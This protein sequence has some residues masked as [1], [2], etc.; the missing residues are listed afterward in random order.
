VSISKAFGGKRVEWPI[1]A[2]LLMVHG[3]LAVLSIR[4]K[5]MTFDE[6]LFTTAGYCH[7]TKNDYRLSPES[8]TLPHRWLALPLVLGD[9]R[10]PPTDQEAWRTSHV[11]RLGYEFHYRLG[12]DHAR[13]LFSARVMIVVLSLAL[14]L[15]VYLW[16]RRLFGPG[17]ARVCLLLYAFSP[18]V[19][20]HARLATSDLTAGLLLTAALAA[21][22]TVLHTA[23]PLTLLASCLAV[24]GAVLA[25]MSGILIL[26]MALAMI[27]IRLISAGPLELRFGKPRRLSRRPGRLL[28]MLA[29]L[30]LHAAFVAL[31]IWA[32]FGFRYSAFA[33]GDAAQAR[34]ARPWWNVLEEVG[35]AGPVVAAAREHRLLP[36]AYL[37]GLAFTLKTTQTRY[38][39]FNG[40]VSIHGWRSFFPYCLLVKTPLAVFAVLLLALGAAARRW[41]G[42]ARG[43]LSRLAGRV[44]RSLYRTA[45]LWVLLAVYWT[46][47]IASNLN[48]GHRHILPTYPA[49]FILCGAAAGW[50]KASPRVGR[51]AAA[52]LAALLLCSAVESLWI[53]PHYLAY[54]NSIAGG[55]DGGHKH[56]VDSSLDWGQD[57]PGLKRWLRRNGLSDAEDA[58]VYLSYFGSGNPRYHALPVRLLPCYFDWEPRRVQ[59]PLRGGTYCVSATMLQTPYLDYPG[60][61]ARAY[62]S[63]YQG[64]REALL[65]YRSLPAD[66]RKRLVE[67]RPARWRDTLRRFEQLQ[68]ARLFAFLR[69]RGFD[70]HVG[71]SILIYRLGDGEVRRALEEPPAE[72]VESVPEFV[73]EES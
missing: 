51:F 3:A 28:A 55:P 52:V 32:V 23:R 38:A 29:I 50:L 6:I 34:F 11:W 48:I 43:G 13:M 44:A 71:Y 14:G 47:A 62:E 45:P 7:W 69:W 72:L 27:V 58:P 2:V 4:R 16:S 33:G 37:Y 73:K 68:L 46:A 56:L 39:F 59:F 18:T 15:L 49:M 64:L 54:F 31:A 30:V 36:E 66:Q 41:Y 35:P 67:S 1:V 21:F 42:A 24:S 60:R 26:P 57:L 5:S 53:H 22:W 20:A 12:N 65:K 17:G 70:D 63:R 9:Y 61:W 40:E 8:G 10:F 25:K 19:L